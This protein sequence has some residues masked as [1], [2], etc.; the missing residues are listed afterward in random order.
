MTISYAVTVFNELEYI[1]KLLPFLLENKR[2]EDE[3]V[4]RWDDSGPVEVWNYLKGL[5]GLE[6]A[7]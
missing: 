2:E 7:K 4:V 1:Q 5:E 3:V 6:L